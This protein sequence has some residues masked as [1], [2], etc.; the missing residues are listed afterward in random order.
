MKL[1]KNNFQFGGIQPPPVLLN[2]PSAL[3]SNKDV[4]LF[5]RRALFGEQFDPIL[6]F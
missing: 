5:K 3:L 4:L 6:S 1:I 2:C